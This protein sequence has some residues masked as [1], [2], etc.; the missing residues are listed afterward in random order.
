MKTILLHG[1]GQTSSSWNSTIDAIGKDTDI[2]CP[3]LFDLLDDKE[4]CY[5]ALYHAFWEYCN[6]FSEPL[7]ICGL[8]LGGILALQYGIENPDKTNSMVLIATQYIMPK[9]LLRIQ[10]TLFHFMPKST[11]QSMGLDKSVF[12][13][14]SKS[15]INLNFQNQLQNISCPV[16]VICGEKDTAN[17]QASQKLQA[18][19]SKAELRIIKNAGHEVNA[20]SPKELGKELSNFFSQ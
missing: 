16:L 1:L 7:N 13:R 8:S 3:N 6:Q 4:I 19:L 5:P 14:L 9:M 15:M 17:K 10:N 12:I 18:Q 20:D 2:L 11:F